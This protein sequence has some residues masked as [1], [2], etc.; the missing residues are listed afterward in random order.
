MEIEIRLD[1]S[2]LRLVYKLF[3]ILIFFGFSLFIFYLNY[4]TVQ[5]YP[6]VFGDEGHHM[7]I[8]KEM[9]NRKEYLYYLD[10]YKPNP[11]AYGYFSI[12]HFLEAF[13]F[14]ISEWFAKFLLPLTIFLISFSMFTIFWKLFDEKIALLSSILFQ[15][16]QSTVIYSVT[17]YVDSLLTL[18]TF[19]GFGFLFIYNKEKRIEYLILS[20]IF[21]S[22][23]LIIKPSLPS[24]IFA[25]FLIL[26]FYLIVYKEKNYKHFFYLLIFPIIVVFSSI[27]SNTLIYN[28]MC[29]EIF[30]FSEVLN[31]YLK[32]DCS[33]KVVDYKDK[34]SFSART[35]QV[36]SEVDVFSMGIT[37]YIDFA[38]GY[39]YFV[40]FSLIV[41]FSYFLIKR[42]WEIILLLLPIFLLTIYSITYDY[43]KNKSLGVFLRAEDTAR[44]L[45]FSNPFIAFYI[46]SIFLILKDLLKFFEKNKHYQ[47]LQMIYVLLFLISLFYISYYFYLSYSQKLDIMQKVKSFSNYFFEACNWVKSN[48]DKNATLMSL[49]GYRVV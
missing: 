20:S 30:P 37:N 13:G 39:S 12:F 3:I 27:F 2:T 41:S 17:F 40:I 19:L 16:F 6:I 4:Q 47:K 44:Y 32:G 7:R 35:E 14:L 8:A 18:F 42:N 28:K 33:I 25:S 5:K 29:I 15:T 31:S 23:T 22:L 34:Y 10:Y 21:A 48:L 43:L 38:Y 24:V 45:Y 1:V 46:S 11:P 49:W 36:G 9:A 26:S